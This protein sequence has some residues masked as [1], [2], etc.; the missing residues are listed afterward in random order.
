[1]NICSV[2]HILETG[3]FYH[4]KYNSRYSLLKVSYAINKPSRDVFACCLGL[5]PL[6]GI[7]LS[8]N[9]LQKLC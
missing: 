3:K 8:A 9:E 6:K 7:S 2:F 4:Q 1:M 5:S